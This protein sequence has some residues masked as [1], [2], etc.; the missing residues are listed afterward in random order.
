MNALQRTL[1]F[2]NLELC[3]AV[4]LMLQ[5]VHGTIT[6]TNVLPLVAKRTKIRGR[7]K[8]PLP[9]H[10]I[11]KLH[12]VELDLARWNPVCRLR[13]IIDGYTEYFTAT[14]MYAADQAE[15]K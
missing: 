8:K 2:L 3:R 15:S 6:A 13:L 4:T 1:P 5:R 10:G 7:F 12:W 9:I 14:S 11:W